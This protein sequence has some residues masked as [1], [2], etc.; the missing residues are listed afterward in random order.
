MEVLG[1]DVKRRTFKV[2]TK[3]QFIIAVQCCIGVYDVKTT[4][5]YGD[6]AK[7]VLYPLPDHHINIHYGKLTHYMLKEEKREYD[8]RLRG[9]ISNIRK[10]KF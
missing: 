4:I 6:D 10:I 1:T 8:K 9:I 2:N 7:Y 3:K 5:Y